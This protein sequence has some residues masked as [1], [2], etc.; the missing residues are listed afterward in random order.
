MLCRGLPRPT[1]TR[2]CAVQRGS[3]SQ[4]TS[5]H[6]FADRLRL[7]RPQAP[8]Q[9]ENAPRHSAARAGSKSSFFVRAVSLA[10]RVS[11]PLSFPRMFPTAAK[12]RCPSGSGAFLFLPRMQRSLRSNPDPHCR[13]GATLC[14]AAVAKPA[15][16]VRRRCKGTIDLVVCSYGL[17]HFFL[18]ALLLEKC[19]FSRTTLV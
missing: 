15:F 12:P 18:C 3:A 17:A 19:G 9:H 13:Q 16:S 6:R 11:T 8:A 10:R 4:V 5:F 1:L 2:A 14:K 7:P